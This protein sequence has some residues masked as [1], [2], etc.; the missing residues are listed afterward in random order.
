[1]DRTDLIALKMSAAL[2]PLEGHR[3]TEDLVAIDSS[4]EE[5]KH[6]TSWQGPLPARPADHPYAVGPDR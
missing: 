4:R 1:M 2:D 3:H 6:G 5:L